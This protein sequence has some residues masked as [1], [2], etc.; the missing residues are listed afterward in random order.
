[1]DDVCTVTH[2]ARLRNPRLLI[3][4]PLA[5]GPMQVATPASSAETGAL[6]TALVFAKPTRYCL[7]PGIMPP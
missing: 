5:Y 6:S 7:L 4:R 2:S 3:Y 1:M